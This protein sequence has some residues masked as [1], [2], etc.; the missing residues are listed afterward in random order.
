MTVVLDASAL[1]ALLR[2]EPG[3]DQVAQALDGA[4][5]SVAEVSTAVISTVNLAEVHQQLGDE[6]PALIGA[7]G[8]VRPVAFSPED[9]Q[10]AA[11]LTAT[12]RSAGLSL[13]DRACLALAIRRGEPV[14][15]A[16]RA[17]ATVAVGV[18][19]QLIR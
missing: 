13:A 16:D 4:A 15:T 18:E 1:I 10:A 8:V 17:W 2:D 9:A 11:A 19:V 3:A 12:T 7:D 14:L 6:L 5:S